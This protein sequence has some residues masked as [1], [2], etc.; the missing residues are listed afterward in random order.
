M[1]FARRSRASIFTRDF[2]APGRRSA[3]TIPSSPV[4]CCAYAHHPWINGTP[5]SLCQH[6]AF[7]AGA[8]RNRNRDAGG[9]GVGAGTL[10]LLLLR[11][12]IWRRHLFRRRLAQRKAFPPVRRQNLPTKQRS[13]AGGEWRSSPAN[14][15]HHSITQCSVAWPQAAAHIRVCRLPP[16]FCRAG[17]L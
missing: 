10:R 9:F 14:W 13:S 5:G 16:H 3:T 17:S 12:P 11:P 15:P 8:G 2:N 1:Q 6:P 7:S 4:G